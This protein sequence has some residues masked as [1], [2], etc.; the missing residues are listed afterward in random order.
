LIALI[1]SRNATQRDIKGEGKDI[2]SKDRE[3]MPRGE[4]NKNMPGK[5]L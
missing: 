3:S 5:F 1:I 4:D 2:G